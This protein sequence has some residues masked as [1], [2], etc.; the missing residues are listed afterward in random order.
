MSRVLTA[1]KKKQLLID[2]TKPYDANSDGPFKTT[3][4]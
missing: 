4:R 2:A 3:L 1:V